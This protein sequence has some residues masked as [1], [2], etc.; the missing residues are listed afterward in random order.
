MDKRQEKLNLVRM[1]LEQINEIIEDQI[2]EG[3]EST[4]DSEHLKKTAL[5]L[6]EEAIEIYKQIGDSLW[7]HP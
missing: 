4:P 2:Y 6:I 1:T 5:Q 7:N 3:I